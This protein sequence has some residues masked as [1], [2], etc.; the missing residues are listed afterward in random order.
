MEEEESLLV[1]IEINF[2]SDYKLEKK[3]NTDSVL[4]L[5]ILLPPISLS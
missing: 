1:S 4:S 2:N 3:T 5:Y